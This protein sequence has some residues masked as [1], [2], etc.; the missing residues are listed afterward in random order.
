MIPVSCTCTLKAIQREALYK[1]HESTRQEKH[2]S[3]DQS[4][5]DEPCTTHWI[6]TS[7]LT[8]STPYSNRSF[9]SNTVLCQTD[10]LDI[11]ITTQ[12]KRS[13][14]R[15]VSDLYIHTCVRQT[16]RVQDRD[17]TGRSRG[18]IRLAL[19]G[20]QSAYMYTLHLPPHNLNKHRPIITSLAIISWSAELQ[21]H[22]RVCTCKGVSKPKMD[23]QSN[24][25]NSLRIPNSCC[26]AS[27]R[28]L[29][30]R[31]FTTNAQ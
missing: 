17:H 11:E 13:T 22:S 12:V 26:Y 14:C 25:R 28:V 27:P 9:S 6:E 8:S 1:H 20:K 16:I 2:C 3:I 4:E 29:P 21:P 31:L 24:Y 5:P 7:A 10:Y 18:L 15:A 23:I 30:T 19:S